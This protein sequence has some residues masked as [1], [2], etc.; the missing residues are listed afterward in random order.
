VAIPEVGLAV[1][2]QGQV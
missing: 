2:M 1:T